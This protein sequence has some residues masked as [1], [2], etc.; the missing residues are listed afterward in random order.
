MIND[1]LAA[2]LA[3]YRYCVWFTWISF[4]WKFWKATYLVENLLTS[5]H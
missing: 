3:Q 4:H 2:R 5:F 1:N